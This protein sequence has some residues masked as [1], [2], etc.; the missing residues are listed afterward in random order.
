MSDARTLSG[1]PQRLQ[2]VDTMALAYPREGVEVSPYMRDGMIDN[3]DHFEAIVDHA[4][5][6]ILK[7]E[8]EEHA[9]LF[10]EAPWNHK[11]KREQLTELMLEKYSVPAFFVCKT[12][13][14]AAFA[15]GRATG[16]KGL[17]FLGLADRME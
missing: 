13:V 6:K 12:A 1:T 7:S 9:V 10:T 5:K 14:L 17:H 3:W 11:A 8:S 15:N 16:M 2:Y 4:F